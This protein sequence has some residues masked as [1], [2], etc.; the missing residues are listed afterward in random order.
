MAAVRQT[1]LRRSISCGGVGLHS[2]AR[3]R[4]VLR[5]A[6]ARTGIVFRRCDLGGAGVPARY[7]RVA[8]TRLGTTI[9]GDADARVG[10]IEHL[11]AALWGCGVDNAF[12]DL[13]GP[14]VPAM[15]GS[16]GP[17]VSLIDRA[18]VVPLDSPRW[19]IAVLRP[20][21]VEEG[22]ARVS[23]HP[24]DCA[25]VRCEID[26]DHPAVGVQS[27]EFAAVNGAFRE[28]I[29]PARTFGFEKDIP[30]MRACGLALG[31]SL[32]NAILLG[33]QEVRNEEGL[34]FPDEFVR[35]KVLDCLGDLYLAGARI[36][37]RVEAHRAGH[38]LNNR[39][40][41]K[42]FADPANW[43]FREDGGAARRMHG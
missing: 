2:G 9:A 1:T 11:M 5:P 26:F 10:T 13:D 12:V 18:G 23:L 3:I 35:H 34:R 32:E 19:S 43:R 25:G 40:L 22:L 27:F 4:M 38:A 17:F 28:D 8:D 36:V 29:A 39:L 24:A 15:D 31:G 7:D 41:R 30:A 14:E 21:S 37:A 16:A 42:L 33:P 6:P 20:V